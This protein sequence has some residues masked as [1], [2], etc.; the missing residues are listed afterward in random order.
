MIDRDDLGRVAY[1]VSA[2]FLGIIGLIWRDFAGVWQPLDNLGIDFDRR[3][4]GTGYAIAFLLAGGATLWRTSAG[5]GLLTLAFLHFLAMLGWIPRVIAHGA[6]TGF[7]EMLLLTI[8]GVVGF[9]WLKDASS[10]AVSRTVEIGRILFSICLL[11]FGL[12]HFFYI[13]ETA[14]M[15][16]TWLPP[17]QVFWAYVTGAFYVLAGVAIA[18]RIRAV[19]AA[20]LTVVM[21]IIIDALVWLPM[22]IAKPEHLT[23]SGNAISLAMAAAT[24]LMA[25]AV[26]TRVRIAQK[27]AAV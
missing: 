18:M 3:L 16:P 14:R 1:A 13:D 4:V 20:R 5:V 19:L 23:W 26:A 10:P 22:L 27:G 17:G 11:V 21:M 8:A 25:D 24:W 7:F 15:V 6:W 2:L 9:A 12:S